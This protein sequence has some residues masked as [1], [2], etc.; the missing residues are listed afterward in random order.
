MT[1]DKRGKREIIE[2]SF[3]GGGGRGA[4]ESPGSGP[5]VRRDERSGWRPIW[6]SGFQRP[7]YAR[8]FQVHMICSPLQRCPLVGSRLNDQSDPIR[9]T[10][11]RMKSY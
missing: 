5:R 9:R 7:N 4:A 3:R 10:V 11:R 1:V 8:D 6:F 2:L